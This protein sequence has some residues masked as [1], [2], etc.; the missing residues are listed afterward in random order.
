MSVD[1]KAMAKA[2]IALIDS[3]WDQTTGATPGIKEFVITEVP[4][5]PRKDKKRGIVIISDISI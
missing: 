2:G 4:R 3:S 1:D 5:K